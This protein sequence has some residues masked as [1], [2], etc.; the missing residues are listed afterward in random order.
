MSWK[1][2]LKLTI[3][4]LIT[5]FVLHNVLLV[6]VIYK[7]SHINEIKKADAIL[8]LGASQWN[9]QPSPVFKARLDYAYE[10]YNNK[11][12]DKIV[13]TG[14]IGKG[15]MIS[16]A[17]VGKNYLNSKGISADIF[18]L[19]KQGRTTWQSL[20]NIKEIIEDINSMIFV[21]DGFHLMRLEKM[22]RD[23]GWDVYI[24]PTPY[25]PISKNKLVEFKYVLREIGVYWLY[26]IFKM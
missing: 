7:K 9:G 2:V 12:A 6:F 23:L 11:L 20:N 22:G 1:R 24:S 17:E 5:V 18:I 8:V 21:S 13:L 4:S 15:K 10:L 19:E 14:G 16:E 3:I 26:K 25:S